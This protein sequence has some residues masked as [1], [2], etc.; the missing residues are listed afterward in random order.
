MEGL[1][2]Q[3]SPFS[4]FF[5]LQKRAGKPNPFRGGMKASPLDNF[6]AFWYAIDRS[7][8]IESETPMCILVNR[9]SHCVDVLAGS[10][11]FTIHIRD[12]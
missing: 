12:F 7:V 11:C 3:S 9:F 2:N 8:L 4:F 5:G 1:G 10:Q 6:H